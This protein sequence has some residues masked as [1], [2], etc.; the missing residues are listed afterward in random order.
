[1]RSWSCPY[2]RRPW[3]A[4]I[5]G[6]VFYT[7]VP[8]NT[9]ALDVVQIGTRTKISRNLCFGTCAKIGT[10]TTQARAASGPERRADPRR[11]SSALFTTIQYSVYKGEL[12]TDVLVY[13][14]VIRIII[15]DVK[16]R[17]SGCDVLCCDAA[18]CK[19]RSGFKFVYTF[20]GPFFAL[21]TVIN[22]CF[23][24]VTRSLMTY[25]ISR[26]GYVTLRYVRR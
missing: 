23:L 7:V 15:Q 4:E 5:I 19:W 18:N 3:E 21:D 6:G 9:N 26:V 25:R 10:R 11:L 8:W 20:V 13:I 14:L 1:M 22:K 24:K 17:I 12:K 2:P 16:L